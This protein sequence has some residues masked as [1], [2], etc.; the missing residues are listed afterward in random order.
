MQDF[1]GRKYDGKGE[2][3]AY[4]ARVKAEAE[5]RSDD[6]IESESSEDEDYNP[7]ASKMSDVEEE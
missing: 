1:D 5:E 4:L 2:P 3:D 6:D 7:D